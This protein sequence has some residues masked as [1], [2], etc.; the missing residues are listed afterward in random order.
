MRMQLPCKLHTTHGI[1]SWH[2][3]WRIVS[4]GPLAHTH[5]GH[6]PASDVRELK[7]PSLDDDSSVLGHL[8]MVFLCEAFCCALHV[9]PLSHALSWPVLLPHLISIVARYRAESGRRGGGGGFAAGFLVGG[10]IFG[11]LGYIFAPQVGFLPC[12]LQ[13][14]LQQ[15]GM[16]HC[17]HPL[18][19]PLQA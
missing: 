15:N 16:C 5:A 17:C 3:A 8:V 13:A 19:S 18:E 4:S 6:H 1:R 12:A 14:L 9:C 7:L 10:T 11:A 2:H